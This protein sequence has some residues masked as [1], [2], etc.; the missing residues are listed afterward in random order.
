MMGKSS[1]RYL[2]YGKGVLIAVLFYMFFIVLFGIFIYVYLYE[3]NVYDFLLI[4]MRVIILVTSI[5]A[6]VSSIVNILLVVRAIRNTAILSANIKLCEYEYKIS[7]NIDLLRFHINEDPEDWLKRHGLTKEEFGYLVASF[8]ISSS[9]YNTSPE[10]QR[11][12]QH[13]SY[14]D[15]MFKTQSMQKAWP[16]V[17]EMLGSKEFVE[18]MDMLY[19]FHKR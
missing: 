10:K 4:Y 14:R 8:S 13:G 6:L 9:L 19:N 17:R 7:E 1:I 18:K 3:G 5:L 16:A 15:N 11:L 2:T 12:F